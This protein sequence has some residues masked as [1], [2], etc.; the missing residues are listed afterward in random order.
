MK[1]APVATTVPATERVDAP[2]LWSFVALHD[3]AVPTLPVSSAAA[4]AWASLRRLLSRKSEGEDAAAQREAELRRLSELR[5]EHLVAPID[6]G[7]TS[8]ALD[9]AVEER[10]D[11]GQLG[12]GVVFL[13]GQPHCGYAE[14][15]EAWAARQGAQI[16]EAPAPQALL[17]R[18][19]RSPAWPAAG[20]PWALPRLERHF[21]RHADGL[22]HVRALLQDLASGRAGPGLV[23]CDSWAWAYLRRVWPLAQPRALTLQAFDAARL[24]RLLTTLASTAGRRPL[25]FR[26]ARTGAQTL[27]VPADD[28]AMPGDEI[29][30]LAAHCRGNPGIAR[31]YW[32]DLLRMQPEDDQ[33][34]AATESDNGSGGAGAPEQVV[35]VAAQLEDPVLP[36]ESDEDLAL[37]L[38]ALLLHGGL[39]EDLLPAVLPMGAS[40]CSALLL[41]LA[42]LGLVERTVDER[43]AV[44]AL[45]YA[46]VRRWL[47]SREH[48]VDDF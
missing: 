23:G 10:R 7:A 16:V 1:T 18:G 2:P 29:E 34:E 47:R 13:V 44:A 41:R 42:A 11:A 6:W 40:R 48:L 8:V 32:R 14:M 4:E 19:V 27:S 15:V 46:M 26:N 25:R 12:G 31:R 22:A 39:P 43:W 5:L 36:V 24:A 28:A 35:W 45:G 20:R 30:R 17:D 33:A 21:L 3:Y 38:H 9:A 37:M